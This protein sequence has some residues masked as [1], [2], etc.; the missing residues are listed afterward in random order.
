MTN[1]GAIDCVGPAPGYRILTRNA[2]FKLSIFCILIHH[3]YFARIGRAPEPKILS[4]NHDRLLVGVL[5]LATCRYTLILIG[6]AGVNFAIATRLEQSRSKTLFG[7]GIAFNLLLLGVF[8]YADFAVANGN[9]L[10]GVDWAL[11]H[12][13]LPLALSFITF[14]QISFL[15]DIL[16]K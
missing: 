3:D 1:S 15:S 12:I 8:K 9:I 11:P 4:S 14:E 16:S 2:V 5:W 10:L 7:C 6:S 13:V